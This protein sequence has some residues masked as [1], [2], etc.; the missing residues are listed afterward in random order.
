MP[1]VTN[2]TSGDNLSKRYFYDAQCL[3][4]EDKFECQNIQLPEVQFG[5]GHNNTLLLMVADNRWPL[6]LFGLELTPV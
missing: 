6:F 4:D 2:V 3:D 5:K 1:Q